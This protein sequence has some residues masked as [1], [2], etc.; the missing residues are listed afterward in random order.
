MCSPCHAGAGRQTAQ[1]QHAR[2]HSVGG[3]PGASRLRSSLRCRRFWRP[4]SA[5]VGCGTNSSL[6]Y[7]PVISCMGAGKGARQPGPSGN[8]PKSP[9]HPV[10]VQPA[11]S[12]PR[13]HRPRPP[14]HCTVWH[15]TSRPQVLRQVKPSPMRPMCTP[16]PA[17]PARQRPPC[18]KTVICMGPMCMDPVR[19]PGGTPSIGLTRGLTRGETTKGLLGF[20]RVDF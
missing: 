17:L 7:S 13:P 3:R 4:P 9:P 10:H 6:C 20:R 1:R 2:R 15:Q 16:G 5:L 12:L 18:M 11:Y 14:P 19:G 8:H